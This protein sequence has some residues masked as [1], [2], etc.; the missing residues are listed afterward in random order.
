MAEDVDLILNA[1]EIDQKIKR[2][3]YEIYE[4]NFKEKKIVFAG[5]SG[6]GFALAKLIAAQLDKIS[7]LETEIIE[8]KVDK[9]KPHFE[10]VELSQ[11][12]ARN[13]SHPVILVDDVLNTGRTL[14]YSLGPFLEL[15][16]KK[17][18]IAVLVDRGYAKF[19]VKATYTGLSLSTTLNDHVEVKLAGKRSE[20]CLT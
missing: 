2:I 5:I 20:V 3:A 10:E 12:I 6:Q 15:K 19:P 7:S 9:D 1:S 11:D 14:M 18:E 13:I 4:Y 16:V 17:I 8:V